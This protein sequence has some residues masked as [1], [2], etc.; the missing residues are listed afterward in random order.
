MITRVSIDASPRHGVNGIQYL[1]SCVQDLASHL[2]TQLDATRRRAKCLPTKAAALMNVAQ[3][4]LVSTGE[5]SISAPWEHAM[6]ARNG[7]VRT[8]TRFDCIAHG[9]P[10]A[11]CQLIY[12]IHICRAIDNTRWQVTVLTCQILSVPTAA[13]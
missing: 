5:S 12:D 11:K 10:L 13:L 4:P 1:A 2:S 9:P 7:K 6:P 3:V 8:S